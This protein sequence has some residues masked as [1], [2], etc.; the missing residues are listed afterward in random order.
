MYNILI[1]M[2]VA[3]STILPLDIVSRISD[4]AQRHQTFNWETVYGSTVIYKTKHVIN[5]WWWS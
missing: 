5:I 3:L 1:I 4:F 2:S